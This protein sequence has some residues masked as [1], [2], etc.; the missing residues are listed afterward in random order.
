[1]NLHPTVHDLAVR[2]LAGEVL[3]LEDH[4]GMRWRASAS[5]LDLILKGEPNPL[6]K[7]CTAFD[8]AYE[9]VRRLLAARQARLEHAPVP[10]HEGA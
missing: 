7:D 2:L 3:E 9:I 10:T 6:L 1:M 4:D 5:R 8:V